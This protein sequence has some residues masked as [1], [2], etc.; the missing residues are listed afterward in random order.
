[1][2]KVKDVLAKKGNSVASIEKSESVL[3]AAKT[4]NEHR[5]GSLVV[6]EGD[7]VI[8]IFT[9]RDILTRVVSPQRVAESTTV[10]EVMTSP[11][12]IC[13]VETTLDECRGVMTERRIRHLPVVEDGELVGIIT[14]GDVL[15]MEISEKA[16]TIQYLQ[17][18]IYGPSLGG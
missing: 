16:E 15:A 5:I 18:Y 10:E 7:R 13:R 4:M 17:E 6:K 1:M 8:G 14:S 2:T 3:A 11:V 12:A 9:E